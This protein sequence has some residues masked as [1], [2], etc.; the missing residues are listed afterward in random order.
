MCCPSV[1]AVRMMHVISCQF[2]C[3]MLHWLVHN[4]HLQ[5]HIPQSTIFTVEGGKTWTGENH[6]SPFTQCPGC[7]LESLALSG[8]LTTGCPT[9]LDP[10]CFLLFCQLLLYKNKEVGWV[11]KNSGNLLHDRHRNFENRFRNS[12]DNWGQSWQLSI[13]I[14]IFMLSCQHWSA[15]SEST[16][17]I[18]VPIK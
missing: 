11:L 13:E 15:I 2:S 12:W 5:I 3:H 14:Y 17:K 10:L 7:S 6:F 4:N 1:A 9:I 8:Q 18:L 16:F